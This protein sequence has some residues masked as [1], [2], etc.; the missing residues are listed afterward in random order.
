MAATWLLLWALERLPRGDEVGAPS[1][2]VAAARQDT[3]APGPESAAPPAALRLVSLAPAITETLIALGVDQELV[4]ASQFCRLGA[5]AE[6]PRV[7]SAITPSYEAIARLAP[8]LILT[9]EVAGEQLGPLS[10][11]APTRRLPWLTLDEVLSSVRNL[12]PWVGRSAAADALATKMERALSTQPP[13]D[14]PRVLLTMSYGDTGGSELWFIR[15][16]SLHGALLRAAGGNNAVPRAITGQPKLSVEEV[17]RVDPDLIILLA[18][19]DQV[20]AAE[21]RRRLE[22]LR[23]LTPLRAVASGGLGLVHERNVFSGGPGVL[24]AIEPLR[25]EIQR[26]RAGAAPLPSWSRPAAAR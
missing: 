6:R 17:L 8:T 4:G 9:S 21:A 12:G 11:L 16:N 10:R 25:A 23:K 26:L 5:L 7:G 19:A 15:D 18:D 24:D 2:N 3:D 1:E 20:D 14:A 13:P 22:P